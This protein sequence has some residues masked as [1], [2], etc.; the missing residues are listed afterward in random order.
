MTGSGAEAIA[1]A[2]EAHAIERY[3]ELEEAWKNSSPDDSKLVKFDQKEPDA[4]AEFGEL[5]RSQVPATPDC[6]VSDGVGLQMAL[7]IVQKLVGGRRLTHA[8]GEQLG[9]PKEAV[10][11]YGAALAMFGLPGAPGENKPKKTDEDADRTVEE[12]MAACT[13]DETATHEPKTE[14]ERR[15]RDDMQS[16]KPPAQSEDSQW[17]T[18][19]SNRYLADISI[20]AR[21]Y[22]KLVARKAE[23]LAKEK[24]EKEMKE[25]EENEKKETKEKKQ[26]QKQKQEEEKGEPSGESPAAGVVVPKSSSDYTGGWPPVDELDW[27]GFTN[28]VHECK[29]L[30][31][32][33]KK[34]TLKSWHAQRTDRANVVEQLRNWAPPTQFQ[35]GLS[36]GPTPDQFFAVDE[37]IPAGD[38]RHLGNIDLEY[39]GLKKAVQKR[40]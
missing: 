5:D 37:S 4:Q 36:Y 31:P 13:I 2:F 6:L 22:V 8:V 32:T 26:K 7:K 15:V 34:G 24:K 21:Q 18:F 9:E 23:Q 35:D 33:F 3:E 28:W 17:E 16:R 40:R 14:L 39:L 25:R 11:S 27:I 38:Q 1:Q 30:D 19:A 20:L 10:M 29:K 12:S